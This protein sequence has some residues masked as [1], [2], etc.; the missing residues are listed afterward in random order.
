MAKVKDN[1][2]TEGLS[3]KIGKRLVFRRLRNGSTVLCTAPDFSDRIFSEGQLT[4]QSR[5]K[6]ASAYARAAAKTTAIYS[7]LAPARG[8]NAYN[9]A[10]SDWFKAPVI[11]RVER[12]ADRIHVEASDNV[13]VIR[14]VITI[15]DEQRQTLEQGEAVR[16]DDVGWEYATSTPPG[17]TV[18]AE[19]I[20]LAGNVARQEAWSTG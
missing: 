17:A 6:R 12:L 20:D 9:L 3:G 2:L 5:F 10:L 4:H 8:T 18:L 11:R 15:S 1:L 19:A 13:L 16:V 14:V 7:E